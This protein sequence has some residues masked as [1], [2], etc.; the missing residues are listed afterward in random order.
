[1]TRRTAR[2]LAVSG[3][4][5]RPRFGRMSLTVE[6]DEGRRR[7]GPLTGGYYWFPTQAGDTIA[8]SVL[9]CYDLGFDADDGHFDMWPSVIDHLASVWRRDA[10][11]LRRRLAVHCYGLPRGRITRPDRRFLLLHGADAPVANW[12]PRVVE[13]FNLDDRSVRLLYDEHEETFT[14]DRRT[15]NA[16]FGL[17]MGRPR[18]EGGEDRC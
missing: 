10:V 9:T 8:W 7:P 15:M 17:S 4:G 6:N 18:T 11:R 5:R 16:E 1:M 12:L 2:T 3:L 14:R 13:R